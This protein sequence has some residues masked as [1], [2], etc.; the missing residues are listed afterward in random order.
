M[1][2][3]GR[4]GQETNQKLDAQLHQIF[5]DR[6]IP[7][8]P[9]TLYSYLREVSMDSPTDR[10]HGRLWF[11]GGLGRMSRTAAALTAVLVVVVGAIAVTMALPQTGGVGAVHDGP[12]ATPN[13]P[14][15][16]SVPV[17]WHFQSSYSS[18][19]SSGGGVGS[20]LLPP[21]PRIAVHVVCNGPD[22]LIVMASTEAGDTPA[23]RPL[24]AASF[25]CTGEGRVVLAAA[26]GQFQGVRAFLVPGPDSIATSV[27]VVSI[28]VPDETPSPSPS[29]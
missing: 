12:S 8:P 24:Q 5:D 20:N 2:F 18:S 7:G 14:A 4:T 23:N 10:G 28:E 3:F 17:G 11:L 9:D 22:E 1:R 19:G 29:R 6:R 21:A 13:V 25:Y 26:T 27:Y 15:A 16:P